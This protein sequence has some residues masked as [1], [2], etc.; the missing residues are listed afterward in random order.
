[1]TISYTSFGVKGQACIKVSVPYESVCFNFINVSVLKYFARSTRN[2]STMHL[3]VSLSVLMKVTSHE[4]INSLSQYYYIYVRNQQIH[5]HGT[6]K[7]CHNV[8]YLG[9]LLVNDDKG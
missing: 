9:V 6:H 2:I 1:M 3:S 4:P 7:Y 8:W 5:V